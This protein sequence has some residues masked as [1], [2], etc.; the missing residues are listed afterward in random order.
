VRTPSR[1]DQD[2]FVPATPPYLFAGST[3]FKSEVL[4]AFEV[5]Y[6]VHAVSALTGSIA[7][8]YN[9]YDHLRSLEAGP[10]NLLANGLEAHSYGLEAE[11]EYQVSGAWR[12]GAGYTHL[13]MNVE[14]M[15]GSTDLTGKAQE[16]D[17]PQDEA[18]LRSSLSLTHQLALDLTARYVGDLP[19]QRVPAYAT[20]D[21]HLGWQATDRIELE[22]VGR[23][24][25]DPQHPEFGVPSS[26]REVQRSIH[27]RATCRF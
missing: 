15:P 27:G 20:G 9:L 6:K 24:L 1:I 19:N 2:L 16:G 21:A 7:T 8:F 25:F 11:A 26:R 13:K 17:S 14:R 10:P 5:G 18:F 22:V 3:S 12:L 23:D 4:C